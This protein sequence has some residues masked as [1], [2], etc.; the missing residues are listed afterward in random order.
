MMI[1]SSADDDITNEVPVLANV[2]NHRFHRWLAAAERFE[3]AWR[4]RNIQNTDFY[5]GDQWTE[6]EKA[7]IESRGQQASTLN[8]VRPTVDLV[9]ALEADRRIDFQVVPREPSDELV[10]MILTELLKQVVDQSDFDYWQS[11][12]FRDAVIGG[13]GW[14]EVRVEKD[15]RGQN[16]VYCGRVPWEQVYADPFHAASDGSDIRW[17]IRCVWT[18]R[19]WV[20]KK[21]PDKAEL[22]ESTFDDD[23]RGV[24][25]EAQQATAD[26]AV[27]PYYDP[28]NG[29]VK[30]CEVWYLDSDR[31]VRHAVFTD[32]IFLKGSPDDDSANVNPYKGNVF[33]LIPVYGFRNRKGEPR[34]LVEYLVCYQQSLNKIN[35]KYL[36]NSSANRIVLEEGAVE[37]AET[38][39]DEWNRPDG[40]VVLAP[41]G[42]AKVRTED[43]LNENSL[44]V[45]YMQFLVGM[46]QRTSGIN[47]AL[48]GLGGTNERSAQQQQSRISQGTFMQ[49]GLFERLFQAR[50]RVA[51]TCLRLIGHYYDDR[52]VARVM[53]PNGTSE[54]YELNKPEGM[55]DQNK[56]VLANEIGDILRYDVV[57][58][59]VPA[60]SVT[61]QNTMQMFAEVAKSGVLPPNVVG[62]VLIELSDLPNK[63]NL[64]WRMEQGLQ[65]Q[66]QAAADQAA[67]DNGTPPSAGP[68][69]P[70]GFPA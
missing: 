8:I 64:I 11:E 5:D 66:A 25:Y 31:V 63:Q 37:D 20:K 1:S 60:F 16:Q 6:E 32:N 27:S 46:T 2:V 42:L 30:L 26:R 7:V 24:E 23:Y 34:G 29:R 68:G 53:A 61:R 38:A 69:A 35:S 58:K 13:R 55:T 15:E 49:T 48:I 10:A 54:F 41:G 65:A 45:Q 4:K 43:H 44:L 57:L 59:P 3:Q 67:M 52:R 51:R 50:K 19:D 56:P 21:Y 47:D 18:D 28:R 33:P 70:P 62:E 22:I 39:R 17:A 36:W 9:L 40:M 12:A 14:I